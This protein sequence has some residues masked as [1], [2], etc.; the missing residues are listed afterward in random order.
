MI[1]KS[2][3][4]AIS[5]L[6]ILFAAVLGSANAYAQNR[7]VSGTVVDGGGEPVI[8]AGVVVVGQSAIGTTTDIDGKFQLSVPAGASL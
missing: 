6:A 3:T 7:S 8:G 5:I 4:S 2:L 1:K